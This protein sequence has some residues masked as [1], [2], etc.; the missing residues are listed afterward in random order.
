MLILSIVAGLAAGC[1]AGIISYLTLRAV[2][3]WRIKSQVNLRRYLCALLFLVLATLGGILVF[4]TFLTV[5]ELVFALVASPIVSF[6]LALCCPSPE[7]D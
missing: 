6:T 7:A 4:R 3:V 2:L 1:Y 5:L